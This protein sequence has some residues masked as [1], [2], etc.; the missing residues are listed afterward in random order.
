MWST[1]VFITDKKND[2]LTNRIVITYFKLQA[3][4]MGRT[5][6]SNTS[7]TTVVDKSTENTENEGCRGC[8]LRWAFINIWR[9]SPGIFAIYLQM[10]PRTQTE[11]EFRNRV[12]D[13]GNNWTS[14]AREQVKTLK[15]D[16]ILPYKIPSTSQRADASAAELR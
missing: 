6:P 11:P 14:L 13:R 7:V 5:A 3:S 16:I 10:T 12:L 9:T 1:R 15:T 4:S 8:C 2:N